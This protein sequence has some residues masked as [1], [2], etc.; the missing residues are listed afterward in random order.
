VVGL[1]GRPLPPHGF[2]TDSQVVF[3]RTC[4]TSRS[5][6]TSRSAS[7]PWGSSGAMRWPPGGRPVGVPLWSGSGGCSARTRV[8]SSAVSGSGC[9]GCA[10]G[11]LGGLGVEAGMW[12]PA[13]LPSD[14]AGDI[15]RVA[16]PQGAPLPTRSAQVEPLKRAYPRTARAGSWPSSP[17]AG[18]SVSRQ[19]R[20]GWAGRRHAGRLRP[21]RLGPRG[22]PADGGRPGRDHR[23]ARR[24]GPAGSAAQDPSGGWRV[25]GCATGSYRLALS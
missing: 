13:R 23:A 3:S 7:P 5:P 24:G 6:W 9:R 16:C 15:R 19:H 18:G 10:P 2:T 25:I 11:G 14:E 17:T 22:R 21:G 20:R 1:R 4:T 8:T 12:R